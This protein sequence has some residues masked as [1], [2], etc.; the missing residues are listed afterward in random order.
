MNSTAEDLPTPAPPTRRMLYDTFVL[1]LDVLMIPFLRD[2]TSL[3]NMSEWLH[4]R[5]CENLLNGYITRMR[6]VLIV[7]W[8]IPAWTSKIFDQLVSSLEE[9]SV[10]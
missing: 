1:F 8:S 7:C 4:R 5:G 6:S 9:P 3:E 2:S 10:A